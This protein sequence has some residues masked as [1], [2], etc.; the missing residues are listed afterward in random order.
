MGLFSSGPDKETQELIDAANGDSVTADKLTKAETG[1]MAWD[2]LNDGPLID[3][4]SD[5]E[6]PHYIFSQQSK[7]GVRVSDGESIQPD[8]KYRTMMAVTD[9]RVL[10]TAG[11]DTGDSTLSID[12][13][14][15]TDIEA[16]S[17]PEK[18]DGSGKVTVSLNTE[19]TSITF[20]IKTAGSVNLADVHS[21]GDEVQEAVDYI[22]S[23]AAADVDR[24]EKEKSS[25]RSARRRIS[26]EESGDYVTPERVNKVKDIL[27]S[28]EEVYYLTR[29]STVDV[30]G[31]SA[32]ESLWGDDRS[33]KTG[34]KGYVRAVITDK[35]VAVKIPQI[36]GNDERS[37]PYESI[38][39]VD[40]DT[41]L[42]NKRLSLQT[43]GQTYHIEA[44]D[45]GKD[46]VRR[47]VK[48]IR[49]KIAESNEDTVVVE[50]S[51]E[52]DPTEQ[53]KNLKEL[54]EEGVLTD[55]EFEE[56]KSDLLDKI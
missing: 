30:E 49:S 50:D 28:G 53:L 14:S 37:V 46:E 41:G 29:G 8:G 7:S 21:D 52:P 6:Q 44:H 42:V 48:F 27:D 2:R 1:R 19:D 5:D 56:K 38:T 34:T 35:R 36:T 32:G 11:G 45:P 51:S 54:H 22:S 55:E 40:L 13:E 12:S 24:T 26:D 3:H 47:A 17:G 33:R 10:F 9:D 20:P 18:S 23:Q 15:I 31:S 25:I 43:P 16:R 4:L 39:S